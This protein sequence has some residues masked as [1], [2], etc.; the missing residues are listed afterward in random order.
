MFL[1]GISMKKLLEILRLNYDNK[2]SHR[3]IEKVVN[4]SRKTISTYITLFE[5]SGL[6][7][8]LESQYQNEAELSKRL[9]P[10]HN[11]D[12]VVSTILLHDTFL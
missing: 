4:L 11:N 9:N 5:N 6:S 8:P 3:Q 10:K 12:K 1:R 7:W 2:I